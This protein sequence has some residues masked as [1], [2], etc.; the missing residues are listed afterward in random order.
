MRENRGYRSVILCALFLL[1]G[2]CYS[3]PVSLKVVTK[4]YKSKHYERLFETWSREGQAYNL[5][6]LENSLKV[7]ATYLSWEMRQVYVAR[8]AYDYGLDEKAKTE[9]LKKEREAFD[10]TNEF[11]VAATASEK[12][13]AQFR[14]PDSPWKITLLTSEG[15]EVLPDEINSIHRPSPM[16]AAYFKYITIYREVF[17]FYFPLD[18]H[19][20]LAPVLSPRLTSFSLVFKGALGRVELKWRVESEGKPDK[21]AAAT[22]SIFQ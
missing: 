4:E 6:T 1:A 7:S 16:L 11:V 22:T 8:Y 18:E 20:T 10:R 21:G 17:R 3:R 2:A 12:K 19:E 15:V 9:M 14:R 5:D 13:W